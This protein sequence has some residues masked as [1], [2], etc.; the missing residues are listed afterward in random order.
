MCSCDTVC[1]T[2]IKSFS[3]AV[4]VCQINVSHWGDHG[5]IFPLQCLTKNPLILAPEEPTEEGEGQFSFFL[6]SILLT[7]IDSVHSPCVDM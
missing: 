5:I 3:S 6:F 1:V 2:L 4:V 7:L